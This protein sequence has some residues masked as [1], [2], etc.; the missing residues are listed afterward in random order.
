MFLAVQFLRGNKEKT[1]AVAFQESF[2]GFL[3]GEWVVPHRTRTGGLAGVHV[4]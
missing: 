4:V 3:Y 1:D 2:F